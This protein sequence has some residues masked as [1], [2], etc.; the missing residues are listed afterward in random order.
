MKIYVAGKITG[1]D[2]YKEKFEAAVKELESKGHAVMNPAVLN[3]GFAH[4]E[5]MHICY[6]MID[7]CDAVYFLN[8]WQNSVGAR[9]EHDYAISSHK[10]LIYQ[11]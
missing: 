7:V 6:A 11:D 2:G 4:H 5:Y 1:L 10:A 9:M 8:N 3:K